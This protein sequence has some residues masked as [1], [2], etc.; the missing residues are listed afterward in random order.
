MKKFIYYILKEIFR[1]KKKY[2]IITL[3]LLGALLII[4]AFIRGYIL[5]GILYVAAAIFIY[6]RKS[7]KDKGDFIWSRL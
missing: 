5:L 1:V 6:I 2:V 7:N 3:I 4:D